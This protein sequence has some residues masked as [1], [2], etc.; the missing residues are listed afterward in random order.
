VGEFLLVDVGKAELS[1]KP[2]LIGENEHPF[3]LK[4]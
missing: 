2:F 1:E 4:F 3:D